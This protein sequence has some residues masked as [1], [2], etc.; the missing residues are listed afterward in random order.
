MNFLKRIFGEPVE[1]RTALD[2]AREVLVAG[3]RRIAA[4]RGCAP[5]PEFPDDKIV[6]IYTRVCTEFAS[7]AKI[8]NERIPGTILNHIALH[9]MV[10]SQ[11]FGNEIYEWQFPYEIEK[12]LAEGL[13]ED[14]KQPL[15]LF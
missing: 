14:F 12:Y 2:A 3:Y 5:G 9:F 15:S 10:M 13:R 4:Q 1:R 6:E 11:G 7:A 8:R